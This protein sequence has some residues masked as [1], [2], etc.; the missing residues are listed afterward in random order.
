[1]KNT[2]SI[3][4]L[5]L[6]SG[7]KAHTIRIWESRYDLIKPHRTKTNIRYYTDEDIKKLLNISVVLK[8]GMKI[9]QAAKLTEDELLSSVSSTD[10]LQD[11][12][13]GQRKRLKLAM[14][15]YDEQGMN[16]IINSCMIKHGT[17][18]TL[19][20]ILGPFIKDIGLLWQINAI[21]VG[22]E[23]FVSNVLKMKLFSLIDNI[24]VPLTPSSPKAI[25]FLPGDEL[26]EL[27]LLYLYYHFKRNA[28]RTLY[29]G[30]DVPLEYV[31]EVADK[32][33]PSYIVSVFTTQ[34]HFEELDVYFDRIADLFDLSKTK[35][36][37]TGSQLGKKELE[38]KSAGIELFNTAGSLKAELL[39]KS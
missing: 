25:L 19:D 3:K 15:E 22:H 16:A 39:R 20:G 28:F 11:N 14:M 32:F 13:E 26:H 34:P 1:M 35:F 38:V 37:L 30:Q 33:E 9:S 31:L 17:L 27:S 36:F 12:F 7:I 2:Y 21:G 18:E 5:E 29:L 6:I 10:T 24:H 8:S 4:E 23:H